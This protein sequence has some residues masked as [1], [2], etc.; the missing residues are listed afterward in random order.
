MLIARKSLKVLHKFLVDEHSNILCA[1]TSLV[2]YVVFSLVLFIFFIPLM[3]Y[4]QTAPLVEIAKVKV[5][6]NGAAHEMHCI[7]EAPDL[8][9]ISSHSEARLLWSLPEGTQVSKGQI[10]AKQDSYYIDRKIEQ[11]KIDIASATAQ[12]DYAN[13]ELNRMSLLNKQQLVSVSIFNDLS[14]QAQQASLAKALL[15]A[16]LKELKYRHKHIVHHAPEDGQILRRQ[17]NL[18]QH[19]QEGEQIL[20][21]LPTS[22][23]EL[24]CEIPLQKYL[25]S[26]QLQNVEFSHV[27]KGDFSLNRQSYSLDKKS[28]TLKI[29]LH[30]SSEMQQKMLVGERMKITARYHNSN[31]TRVPFDALELAENAS[32]VWLV[33]ADEIVSRI[34]VNIIETQKNY[35][36]VKSDLKAGDNVVTIGKQGLRN[37]QLVNTT[38]EFSDALVLESSL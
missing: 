24:M 34:P 16:R 18:E 13:K 9:Q 26:Q 28:Q 15:N 2:S 8:Y 11:I 7:V 37:E 12:D 5:W 33:N 1:L 32:F 6:N 10:V 25:Q 23:N 29:Y 17:A 31:L 22:R 27:S 19:L 3:S 35:F 20:Q 36:L 14:K 30:A 4:G 38:T 21:F